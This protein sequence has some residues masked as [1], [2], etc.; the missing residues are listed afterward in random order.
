MSVVA[1]EMW[2]PGW[3]P[4][5]FFFV[6]RRVFSVIR[7]DRHTPA[8]R[9]IVLRSVHYPLKTKQIAASRNCYKHEHYPLAVR[10]FEHGESVCTNG[11]NFNNN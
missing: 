6:I 1:P 10:L 3:R 9:R 4:A 5:A 11:D 8:T 7:G 2:R